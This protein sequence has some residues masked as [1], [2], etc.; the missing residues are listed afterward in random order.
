MTSKVAKNYLYNLTYQISSLILPLVT[1]PYVSRILKV[2]GIGINSFTSANVQ[3]FIIVGTLGVNLYGSRQIAYVRDSKNKLSNTFWEII[4]FQMM[5]SSL[6]FIALIIFIIFFSR[7]NK[8]IY[9]I[10]SLNLIAAALDISW[11]FMGI[12]DFKKTV[13]RNMIVKIIGVVLIFTFVKYTDQLWIYILI[14][15]A[16]ILLGQIVM[17]F[18]LP[19]V[20]NRLD[21]KKINIR[22]HFIPVLK[23]FI[24]Q[25]A[26]QLYVVMDKSMTG[27]LST[28]QEV[29]YYDQAQKIVKMCLAVV[30]SMGTVML[31][32]MAN[33][34]AKGDKQKVKEY[35]IKSFNFASYLSIPLM[36]GISGAAFE[37]VPWFFGEEFLKVRYLIVVISPIIVFISWSNVLGMQ[38]LL[39]TNKNKMFTL[40]VSLGAAVNFMLNLMLIPKY[41]SLGSS[42][43]TVVAEIFVTVVQ[44]YFVKTFIDLKSIIRSL[45][46]YFVSAIVMLILIKSIGMSMG[47][48]IITTLVQGVVGCL[49]YFAVLLILRDSLHLT[50][51]KCFTEKILLICSKRT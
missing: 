6:S 28:N 15:S 4:I 21:I 32:R 29:G 22:Q 40:S 47:A 51:V 19:D 10:Q 20:V 42:I 16:S 14:N 36:I 33:T 38:F 49:T 50:I 46:N 34:F 41:D 26:I 12:E 24:P 1:V 17:W 35:L 7:E 3:Y 9:M 27:W 31:P 25:I 43:A 13:T 30:T 48:N 45:T 37:Y 18:Y 2:D 23:L 8:I 44:I 39:P 11:F 5:T